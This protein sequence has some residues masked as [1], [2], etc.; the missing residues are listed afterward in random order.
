MNEFCFAQQDHQG[1]GAFLNASSVFPRRPNFSQVVDPSSVAG[2]LLS[3][4]CKNDHSRTEGLIVLL[5]E[6]G[7]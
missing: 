7:W 5:W 1:R 2:L 3:H 4:Q 6:E